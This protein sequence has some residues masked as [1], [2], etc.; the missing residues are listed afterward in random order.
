MS[1]LGQHMARRGERRHLAAESVFLRYPHAD[2]V[3]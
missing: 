3:L 1:K 2:I